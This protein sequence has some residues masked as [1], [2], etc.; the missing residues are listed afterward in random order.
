M[1][2]A[3]AV[4]IK[5]IWADF[6]AENKEAASYRQALGKVPVELNS[7]AGGFNLIKRL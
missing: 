7:V 6:G 2:W 1:F 3:L 5:W 4:S